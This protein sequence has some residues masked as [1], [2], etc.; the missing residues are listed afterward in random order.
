M[1]HEVSFTFSWYSI[2]K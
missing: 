2:W 1:I